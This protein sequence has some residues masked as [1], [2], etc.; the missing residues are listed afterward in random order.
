M[1]AQEHLMSM[2]KNGTLPKERLRHRANKA[3]ISGDFFAVNSKIIAMAAKT[4]TLR[5]SVWCGLLLETESEEVAR[6]MEFD[7]RLSYLLMGPASNNV[8][9]G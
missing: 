7:S 1:A 8:C 5:A 2:V 6:Q 9:T 3:D 4:S